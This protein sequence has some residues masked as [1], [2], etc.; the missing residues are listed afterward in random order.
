LLL[1]SNVIAKETKDFQENYLI[2][3]KQQR[4][5]AKAAQ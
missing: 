4:K 5:A 1:L 3:E 2:P